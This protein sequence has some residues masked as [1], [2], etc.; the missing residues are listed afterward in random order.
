M[1]ENKY[2]F[3]NP[4][5]KNTYRHTTS[6]ILA[7][8]V[9]RLYPEVKLAIGPAIDNGFYYDFDAPFAITPEILEKIEAEMRMVSRRGM[10]DSQRGKTR[11]SHPLPPVCRRKRPSLPTPAAGSS[12]CSFTVQAA[13][14]GSRLTRRANLRKLANTRRPA[15]RRPPCIRLPKL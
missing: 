11:D 12:I 1:E 8:A 4:E 14:A 2:T 7:Q 3:E 10:F 5:F 15:H 13:H 6:H 9:K